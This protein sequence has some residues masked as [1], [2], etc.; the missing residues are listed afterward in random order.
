MNVK[1]TIEWLVSDEPQSARQAWLG[2]LFIGF[3]AFQQNVLGMTGLGIVL[4]IIIIAALAPVIAP[5][6]PD[7]QDLSHRLEPSS[8]QHWLGTDEFGRDIFS[9]IIYG[10]T[11]T[12]QFVTLVIVAI[13]PIGLLIGVTAAYAGGVVD[14]ILM[15]I[16]DIFLSFPRLILALAFV[17]TLGPGLGNAMIAI[18]LTAW[19]P[20]ARVARAEAL[21]I[22]NSDFI[23]AAKIAGAPPRRIVLG[24][25]VP[26]CIPTIIVR[27]SLDMGSIIL[28]AASLGFLG[29]GAQPPQPE[30]GAMISAGR[31][32]FLEQWWI[33]TIPGIAICIATIGFNLL[34]DGL[35]DVLD[36]KYR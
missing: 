2:Q 3:R 18:V 27:G 23:S 9:R 22:R 12:L 17:A 6:A 13:A 26:L 35:R 8:A 5:Y 29:L 33:S 34:G 10:T 24:H 19:P 36:P 4:G 25:I 1:S 20:Y 30:W 15:R 31:Q 21:R 32:Y 14:H 16:T 28:T 7:A 11:Y